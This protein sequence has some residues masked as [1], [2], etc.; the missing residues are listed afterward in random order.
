MAISEEFADIEVN[1]I[2][3]SIIFWY[4]FDYGHAAVEMVFTYK[5]QFV[6]VIS[7]G[8]ADQYRPQ[9]SIVSCHQ[10]Y[11]DV[12]NLEAGYMKERSSLYDILL[13]SDASGKQMSYRNVF[14]E[15]LRRIND[16]YVCHP[17][18]VSQIIENRIDLGHGCLWYTVHLYALL[19][20]I[21]VDEVL[22]SI[23]RPIIEFKTNTSTRAWTPNL[24]DSGRPVKHR[25]SRNQSTENFSL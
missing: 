24:I 10:F 3:K 14:E 12:L 25:S 13:Q 20:G 4:N 21:G 8:L 2:L 22:A 9:Y 19:R 18:T 17:W 16:L 15:H 1:A 7:E 11:G 5:K 23:S 6:T